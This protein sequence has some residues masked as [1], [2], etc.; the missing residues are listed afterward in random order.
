MVDFFSCRYNSTCQGMFIGKYCTSVCQITIIVVIMVVIGVVVYFNEYIG[1]N[2]RN[3]LEQFVENNIANNP[4]DELI[5]EVLKKYL[6]RDATAEDVSKYRKV[7]AQPGDITGLVNAIKASNEY[8]LKVRVDKEISMRSQTIPSN[9]E[10][11]A[12]QQEQI[13]NDRK[14]AEKRFQIYK[15]VIDSYNKVLDRMPTSG[16]LNYYSDKLTGDNT[17]TQ[18]RLE[19]LLYGSKEYAI[20]EKN[21]SNAVF[22][23]L[24]GRITNTQMTFEVN[25]IYQDVFGTNAVPSQTLEDFLKEK[26]VEYSLNKQ[27]LTELLLV[28]KDVDANMVKMDIS[29]K[30]SLGC[31]TSENAN[32]MAIDKSSN[33]ASSLLG[34]FAED[35]IQ[36]QHNSNQKQWQSSWSSSTTPANG[37]V[38]QNVYNSPNIINII[39]PSAEELDNI[40]NKID[41]YELDKKILKTNNGSTSCYMQNSNKYMDP[42]TKV[43]IGIQDDS[44]SKNINNPAQQEDTSYRTRNMLAEALNARNFDD[45][46]NV[47]SRTAAF[48]RIEDKASTLDGIKELTQKTYMKAKGEPEY[49]EDV[50]MYGMP[51]KDVQYTSI[52]SLMPPFIYKELQRS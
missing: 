48:D 43:M 46:K 18:K 7:M 47:C 50:K 38:P 13:T 36:T 20:L 28:L 3:K 25:E 40:M 52:G 15:T 27:R 11:L 10:V 22:S 34:V 37:S 24:P 9:P 32:T 14:A 23:E 51:L 44:L 2:G 35:A 17:F 16:E 8:N 1:F 45:L 21:Q 41:K 5:A 39:N 42:F 12:I 30:V 29:G 4:D 26:Y 31:P 33:A 49:Y 19:D 6:G